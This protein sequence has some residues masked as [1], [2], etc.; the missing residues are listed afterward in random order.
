MFLRASRVF[1]LNIHLI[2][3][4]ILSLVFLLL[5]Y[6]RKIKLENSN[7][8][9]FRN[10]EQYVLQLNQPS[11][12]HLPCNCSLFNLQ[13]FLVTWMSISLKYSLHLEV[14]LSSQKLKYSISKNSTWYS[15]INWDYS[16]CL[17]TLKILLD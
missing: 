12:W 1:P 15:F 17:F 2:P 10:F 11:W 6:L 16:E 4:T 13:C 3:P 8:L 5:F 9:K 7:E 14:I